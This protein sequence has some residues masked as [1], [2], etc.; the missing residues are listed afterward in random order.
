MTADPWDEPAEPF[1]LDALRKAFEAIRDQSYTL[2][3]AEA[4]RAEVLRLE[5]DY[6]ASDDFEDQP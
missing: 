1:N 6:L 2:S 3:R 4:R 5:A